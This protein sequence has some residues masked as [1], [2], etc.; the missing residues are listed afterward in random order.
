MQQK[1]SSRQKVE[2]NT[3]T[4]LN[5]RQVELF[6][7]ISEHSLSLEYIV[8]ENGPEK[9]PIITKAIRDRL[10]CHFPFVEFIIKVSAFGPGR[11]SRRYRIRWL[12]GPSNE[13]VKEKLDLIL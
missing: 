7:D 9:E 1:E 6:P 2:K 11:C 4:T 3:I 8:I 5:S 13:E 12:S 10:S